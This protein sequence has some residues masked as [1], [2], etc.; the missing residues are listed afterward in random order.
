MSGIRRLFKREPTT[1]L[2]MINENRLDLIKKAVQNGEDVNQVFTEGE[3]A[4]NN[5]PARQTTPLYVAIWNGEPEL[6]KCW[7]AGTPLSRVPSA[8]SAGRIWRHQ[9]PRPGASGSSP[10]PLSISPGSCAGTCAKH[11]R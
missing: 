10:P 8:V 6:P 11:G 2:G 9:Y 4:H 3:I 7:A 1:F 5:I